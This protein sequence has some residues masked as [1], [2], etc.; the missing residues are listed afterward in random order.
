MAD[1]YEAK[2]TVPAEALS[3]YRGWAPI[4]AFLAVLVVA[5]GVLLQA[6]VPLNHD[7][8]WIAHSASWLFDG[9]S[10]GADIV[11]PSPPLAWYLSA[12]ASLLW[13]NGVMQEV[14]AIRAYF[15]L[16]T[17]LML[18]LVRRVLAKP[19]GRL[20]S[21][22]AA[23]LLCA[24][25]VVASILPGRDFGQR[26]VVAVVMG[27]PYM[28]LVA[29]QIDS[30]G[31]AGRSD[32]VLAGFVAGIGYCLKPFLLVIPAV[33][34]ILR[35]VHARSWRIRFAPEAVAIM[36]T[37]AAYG[38]AVLV[39]SPRYVTDDI[40]TISAV[41]WAYDATPYWLKRGLEEAVKPLLLGVAV[42]VAT[43]SVTAYH[44]SIGLGCLGAAAS[45]WIQGKGFTYHAFPVLALGWIFLAYATIT[46]ARAIV[47]V[48]TPVL[49]PVV[50]GLGV[51]GLGIVTVPGLRAPVDHALD[52]YEVFD[53]SH[54]EQ[55]QRMTSLID[56]LREAG[57]G[58]GKQVFALT[59]HPGP[60]FPAVNYLG[61]EW[62]GRSATQFAIPALVRKRELGDAEAEAR[63]TA[64]AAETIDEVREV[65]LS[66]RPFVVL[67]DER[68]RRLGIDA[69]KFDHVGFYMADPG[70][71]KAWRCYSEYSSLNGISIFVLDQSCGTPDTGRQEG[72]QVGEHVDGR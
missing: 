61:A 65:L 46:G 54:G 69:R 28:L 70:F 6:S 66:R 12:P 11:D 5:G 56:T 13:R 62:A 10:I 71:R 58:P 40:P 49:G 44:W 48:V 57:V 21:L 39:L 67:V 42:T 15:W 53:L 32:A 55:G 7:V 9:K 16:L 23:V 4:S 29:R 2:P 52:W 8:G 47:N 37:C 36:A 14:D 35:A 30:G 51:L 45:Y 31:V 50:A 24:A 26:D 25:A 19:G 17:C 59:T 3:A 63:V 60:A 1:E 64:L 20:H 33:L 22:D 72:F 68:S 34:E 18:L 41:Y 43:R 27:L 38:V